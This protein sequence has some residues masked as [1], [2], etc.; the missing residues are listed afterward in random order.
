MNENEKKNENFKNNKFK[1]IINRLKR[2]S[3]EIVKKV[4]DILSKISDYKNIKNEK[5][6]NYKRIRKSLFWYRNG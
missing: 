1:E 2:H 3:I 4:N 5:D 6:I